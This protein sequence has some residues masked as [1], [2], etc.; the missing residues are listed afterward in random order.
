MMGFTRFCGHLNGPL[1]GAEV[2]QMGKDP[3]QEGHGSP[4]IR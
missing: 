1:L 2:P 3:K 4:D